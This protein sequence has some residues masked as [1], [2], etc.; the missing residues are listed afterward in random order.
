MTDCKYGCRSAPKKR[1]VPRFFKPKDAAR[2]ICA[3][4]EK[5]YSRGDIAR[6]V[7]QKCGEEVEDCDCDRMRATLRS[8]LG[9]LA[10]AIAA[11]GAILAVSNPYVRI[12]AML[13]GRRAI[14]NL[15]EAKLQL[16]QASDIIE[17]EL[18][19]DYEII[20]REPINPP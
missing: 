10:V 18:G 1:S 19:K 6:A 17:L 20:I 4:L 9:A 15:Q 12:L 13:V 2:V 8:V 16:E 3:V 7:A 5:G 14:E 11:I